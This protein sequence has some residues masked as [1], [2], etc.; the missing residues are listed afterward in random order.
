MSETRYILTVVRCQ[1]PDNKI[2]YKERT[3]RIR[4]RGLFKKEIIHDVESRQY[5]P[6]MYLFKFRPE[7]EKYPMREIREIAEQVYKNKPSL[8]VAVDVQEIHMALRHTSVTS[9]ISHEYIDTEIRDKYSMPDTSDTL[10]RMRG[11]D[12]IKKFIAEKQCTVI[13]GPGCQEIWPNAKEG[14]K[15]YEEVRISRS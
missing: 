10:V 11:D 12:I 9:F 3:T 15:V 14:E 5:I 2:T 1:D 7:E 13:M 8:M 4:K 6:P